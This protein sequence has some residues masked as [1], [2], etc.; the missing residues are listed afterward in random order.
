MCHLAAR[1]L[2][3]ARQAMADMYWL[4]RRL[5]TDQPNVAPLPEHIEAPV[6]ILDD[7]VS[8]SLIDRDPPEAIDVINAQS[9]RKGPIQKSR[10]AHQTVR[11]EG[12]SKDPPCRHMRS[13]WRLL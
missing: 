6:E 8:V 13:M 1:V 9:R 3:Q 2:E 4:R 10:I 12:R 5:L 7:N 11:R